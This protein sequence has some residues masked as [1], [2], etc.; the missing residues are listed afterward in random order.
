MTSY[1]AFLVALACALCVSL[2]TILGGLATPGYSHAAQFISELGATGSITEHAVRFL[3]FLPAG[4]SLLGFCWFAY[5]AL[6]KSGLT[7]AALGGLAVYAL[8]YVAAAF[9]PCDLG[10]R[11]KNPSVSQVVHN[12]VG[13]I[14]YLLAPGFLLA[15]AVRSRS[16]PGAAHMPLVGFVAAAVSLVGLM[17]LSPSPYMGVSQR[18]IEVSVLAWALACGWTIHVRERG[19]AQA[20]AH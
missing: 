12:L 1:R 2:M 20:Q 11:P 4:V 17:S 6:P 15:L 13:G 19:R 18:A 9:F 5:R 7:T 3:G 16:W 8:G 10:C 14:G